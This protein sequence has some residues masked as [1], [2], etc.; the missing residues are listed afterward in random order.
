MVTREKLYTA[1]DL[2]EISHDDDERR[3]ELV[4]GVIYDMPPA[5]GL[6]GNIAMIL[7]WHIAG[8]VMQ[9]DLGFVT[10]AETGF[11]LTGD[12]LNVLA[13]DVGFISKNRLATLPEGYIPLAPDLA[14]EVV[15]PNDKADANVSAFRVQSPVFDFN[16]PEDNILGVPGGGSGQAVSDGIYLMLRPLPAG[17]HT[18]RFGG[19]FDAFD[20]T[21]D[22]TYHITVAR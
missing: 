21:L 14:V 20:F 9:N 1:H 16:A 18:V 2:W 8:F 19:T 6:H 11:S 22:I 13:P 3:Y 10:A 4:E 7:G 17:Q 15:S 5:G 12:N